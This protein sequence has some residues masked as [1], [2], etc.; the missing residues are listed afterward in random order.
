MEDGRPVHDFDDDFPEHVHL[1]LEEQI[2]FGEDE[3]GLEK[4]TL[5]SVGIDIGSSTSHL[6]FSRLTLQRKGADLSAVFEVTDR[7]VLYQSPILLTPYV[8]STLIDVAR[9]EEFIQEHYRRAGFAPSD[10]D[11][12]VV[13]ITGE[14]LNKENA[15]PIAELFARQAGRFICA[16]AGPHHEALLAAHGSGAVAGSRTMYNTALNVDVGGGT[17]KLSLIRQGEV[18]GTAAIS[19]GAR[20]LAF[21]ADGRVERVEAPARRVLSELGRTVEV[22]DVLDAETRRAVVRLLVGA[23]FEVLEGAPHSPLAQD[24]MVIAPLP[25]YE[26]LA[27]IDYVVFS[28]GV[29]EYIYGHEA[30]SFGDLGAELGAAIRHRIGHSGT[31]VAVR[32]PTHGIRATVIGAGEY[33]VQVSGMTSYISDTAALPAFGLKV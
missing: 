10:V 25:G 6:M 17:S 9:L 16:S 31:R 20:L 5:T 1:E 22:G 2:E 26:G 19:V 13:G 12:G 33:T 32:A 23:L 8:S 21:D 4:L 11:T 15:Q 24:L 7:R 3:D 28:G 30:A 27:S 14:A 29:S 18:V